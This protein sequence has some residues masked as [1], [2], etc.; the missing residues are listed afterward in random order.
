MCENGCCEFSTT[1]LAFLRELEERIIVLE[2]MVERNPKREK[3]TEYISK[4]EIRARRRRKIFRLG[5]LYEKEQRGE[6]DGETRA[7]IDR[8][9]EELG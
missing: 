7:E 4:N 3:H 9:V 6:G 8:L 5:E 1:E 2:C